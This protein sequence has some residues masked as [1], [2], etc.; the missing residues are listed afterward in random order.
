[1]HIRLLALGTRGDAQPYLALALGLKAAG[2]NVSIGTTSDFED[3][4]ASY[5]I[6][7]QTSSVNVREFMTQAATKKEKIAA[8]KAIVQQMLDDMPALVGDADALIYSPASA[9]GAPHVA[10]K[11]GIPSILGLLQP[12]LHPTGEFPVIG[13]PVLPFGTGY[14]RFS[15]SVFHSLLWQPMK[16]TV[17]A[18]R[19]ESLGLPPMT[20]NPVRQL[21]ENGM[22]TL[23]GFSPSVVPKPT[24]WGENICITGYWFLNQEAD[25]QPPTDLLEFLLAGEP[26]V[27]IGFGSMSSK[28]PEETAKIVLDA[29]EQAGVRGVI[30]S[31]W[32][33]LSAS[34]VPDNVLVIDHAPHDWLFPKMAAV[35]HH[36]GAGTTAAGLRAGVPS[37]IV[38]TRGDQPFWGNV[39][40][41]WAL[42]LNR[43]RAKNSTPMTWLLPSG[44]L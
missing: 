15:Y 42:A 30:A 19:E 41:N 12:Y 21:I 3:F 37:V 1:M 11:R 27:Y 40:M 7:V 6:P 18:W 35:V 17:N 10:E 34:D 9:M 24:N 5:D 38:P 20:T 31:G 22:F 25:Y 8:R 23:Y 26:P 4:I 14:N 13:L 33:G 29:I 43:F 36:G 39:F 28:Q 32:Q 16:K 44:R 2:F